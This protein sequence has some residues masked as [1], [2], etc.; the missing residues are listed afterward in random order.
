VRYPGVVLKGIRTDRII[1]QFDLF[2]TLLEL[3]GLGDITIENSPGRSFAATLR[4]VEQ[5]WVDAG[6][7]EYITVR[8]I[9]TQDWKYVKR[10][11]GDPPEL[12]HLATDPHENENL[13]GDAN[14]AD[15]IARLDAQLTEF[16]LTYADEKYDP[17][18]GGTA[19]ALMMYNDKNEQF[20]VEFPDWRPPFIERTTPFS[21]L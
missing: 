5:E 1:N 20:V 21:D 14:Y 11:F 8:A 3:V 6:F 15:V 12:Y 7:F 18:R 16:F 17:W 2:P 4:N 19:K 13:A 9:A 10:L